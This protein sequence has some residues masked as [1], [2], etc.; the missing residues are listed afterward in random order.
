[1]CRKSIIGL[2][3][4][5]FWEN[6]EIFRKVVN[7]FYG[8]RREGWGYPCGGQPL[9]IATYLRVT[10]NT[11]LLTTSG[12][13]LPIRSKVVTLRAVAKV[14]RWVGH[15][16]PFVWLHFTTGD[17]Q[18]LDF[19]PRYYPAVVVSHLDP[20]QVFCGICQTLNGG[21]RG[22]NLNFG[23]FAHRNTLPQGTDIIKLDTPNLIHKVI[24]SWAHTLTTLSSRSGWRVA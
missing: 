13:F 8:S 15:S 14:F 16:F 3:A 1:M 9:G 7:L 19:L 6:G 20:S 23:V 24:H 11:N 17:R 18:L 21:T 22:N 4:H 12:T 2:G 5:K 10:R